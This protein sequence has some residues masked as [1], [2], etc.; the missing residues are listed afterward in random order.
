[1]AYNRYRKFTGDGVIYSVPFVP[2]KVKPT[3]KYVTYQCGRTRL[4]ILSYQY[5]GDPN[6]EWLILQANPEFGP[7]E[8]NI[9]NNSRI[10]IPYPLESTITQYEGDI[11]NYIQLYGLN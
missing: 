2:I 1:M 7:M 11:D 6:Y 5:Y 8:Y 3:D 10:R 4:D 9:P